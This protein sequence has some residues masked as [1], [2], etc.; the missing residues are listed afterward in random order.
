MQDTIVRDEAVTHKVHTRSRQYR[1]RSSCA[2]RHDHTRARSDVQYVLRDAEG[3]VLYRGP[4]ECGDEDDEN[5]NEHEHDDQADGSESESGAEEGTTPA[6]P[7]TMPQEEAPQD[8]TPETMPQEEAPQETT[9]ETMTP[10]RRINDVP[11]EGANG[12]EVEPH[13]AKQRACAEAKPRDRGWRARPRR[14]KKK[15]RRDGTDRSRESSEEERGDRGR[16]REGTR[17]PKRSRPPRQRR[18]PREGTRPPKRSRP[19]RQ[20]E[21]KRSGKTAKPPE[22]SHPHYNST[23]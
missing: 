6:V 22:P 12:T 9:S 17:P 19:P 21:R 11:V 10:G 20:W 8:P 23:I 13:R 18:E 15:R 7:D 4:A 1:T 16:P 3:K 14:R 5:E 2:R